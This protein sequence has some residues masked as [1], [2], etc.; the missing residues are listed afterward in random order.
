MDDKPNQLLQ[1][2]LNQQI[3]QTELLRRNLSRIRFSLFGLI[4]F[5][6]LISVVLGFGVYTIRRTARPVTVP[7]TPSLPTLPSIPASPFNRASPFVPAPNT[8]YEHY[9]T[10]PNK[11]NTDPV[12]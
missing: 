8:P 4:L 3:Q 1:E 9:Q 10:P 12:G 2:I 6:T 11:P 5:M 7:A